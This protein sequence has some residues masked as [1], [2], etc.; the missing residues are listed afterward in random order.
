MKQTNKQTNVEIVRYLIFNTQST[1]EVISGLNDMLRGVG[2]FGVF[3]VVWG[4][5]VWGGLDTL[6]VLCRSVSACTVRGCGWC[7]DETR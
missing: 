1:T 6:S 5:W 2:L 4:G 3:V 7:V